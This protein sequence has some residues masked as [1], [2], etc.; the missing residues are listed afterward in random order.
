MK[1]DRLIRAA[2]RSIT[3]NRMRSFLTMLGIIIGVG[4]VIALVAIGQGASADIENQIDALGTNLIM[5]RSGSSYRGGVSRGAGSLQTLSME[6]IEELRKRSTLLDYVSPDITVGVQAIAMDKNWATQI[7][8]VSVDYPFIRNWEIETGS[9]FTEQDVRGRRK[10]AVLGDTVAAEIF[11]ER[12]PLGARI[13]LNRVP[14]TVIGTLKEKGDAQMGDQDDLILAPSTT[15]LYRLSDGKT[16]RS[17]QA[18]AKE[19]ASM[20]AVE[21]EIRE[22]L[23]NTHRLKAADEDDFQIRS[24]TE[25]IERV[26]GVTNTMTMLLGAIAAVSLLVGG[27]GIMNIML[28]SVTERTREIG[29]RMA[30]GARSGDILV[31]FLVEAVILSLLG[32]FIGILAG[33]GL[34]KGISRLINTGFIVDP[35]ITTIAVVFSAAVGVFF[36][37]YPAR[38][39]SMLNPIEALHYE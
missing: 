4:A 25:I 16:V 27:I 21:S 29:I 34:G 18:S 35:V 5:I 37:F 17:I 2:V 12:D 23:R 39:A 20:E 30:V 22:I 7:H 1:L 19:N 32:G 26:T 10:V 11:G 36:G 38:K 9:F 3:R 13:R 15:V 31:Q 6:D 28:V 14:F 24:Q 33:L 8:G